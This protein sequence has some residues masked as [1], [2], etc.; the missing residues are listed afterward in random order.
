MEQEEPLA[1]SQ[2]TFVENYCSGMLRRV[3]WWKFTD[4]SEVLTAIINRANFETSVYYE[5]TLRNIPEDSHISTHRP[6]NM[7]SRLSFYSVMSQLNPFHTLDT[8]SCESRITF[9]ECGKMIIHN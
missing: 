4:V 9:Y 8:T 6:E 7:K 3:V 2:K 5:A 1:Y